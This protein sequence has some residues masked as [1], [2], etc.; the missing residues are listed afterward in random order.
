[1]N[2]KPIDYIVVQGVVTQCLSKGLFRVR[3]LENNEY[4]IAHMSGKIRRNFIR[5]IVGDHVT[6]EVSSYDLTRG[7]II[8]RYKT[9]P[10]KGKTH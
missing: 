7:R 6:L 3:I 4:V 2:N 9:P 1:M 10:K 5:I 8:Y